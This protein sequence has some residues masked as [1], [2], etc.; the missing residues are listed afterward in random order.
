MLRSGTVGSAFTMG[1]SGIACDG[2]GLIGRT[3]HYWGQSAVQ[4]LQRQG[5][6]ENRMRITASGEACHEA[7]VQ[8][9][10]E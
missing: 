3:V 1:T 8:A 10:R 5:R 4:A 6:G 7:K 9:G 2:T